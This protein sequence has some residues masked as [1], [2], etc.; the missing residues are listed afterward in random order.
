MIVI[1]RYK[2][3]I[4]WAEGLD[5]IVYNK[6]KGKNKLENIGREAHTYLHHIITNYDN[7]TDCVFTQA[8]PFDHIPNFL[9]E[10]K[11]P[12]NDFTTFGAL[13]IDNYIKEDGIYRYGALIATKDL[14]DITVKLLDIFEIKTDKINTAYFG[15]F[16]VSKNRILRYSKEQYERANELANEP[17]F[18]YAFE[19]IWKTLYAPD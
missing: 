2:E 11:K 13:E 8:N 5:C 3:E 10:L 9:N 15:I 17:L 12:F 1:S 16:G 7:L 6:F 14:R 19:L 18:A 4:K